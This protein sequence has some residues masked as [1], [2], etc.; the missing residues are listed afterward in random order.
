MNV[1]EE[2]ECEVESAVHCPLTRTASCTACLL[3]IQ[4][5]VNYQ[6]YRLSYIILRNSQ[7]SRIFKSGSFRTI[8]LGTDLW[9][10]SSIWEITIVAESTNYNQRSKFI[11]QTSSSSKHHLTG[12]CQNKLFTL[13]FGLIEIGKSE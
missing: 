2:K 8:I 11:Q 4:N 12:N 9:A 3:S 7:D 13:F 1:T 10:G 6:L 5:V